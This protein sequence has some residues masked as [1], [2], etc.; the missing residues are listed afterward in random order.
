MVMESDCLS[1][2]CGFNSR[3]GGL[4]T[5]FAERDIMNTTFVLWMIAAN[6][7]GWALG[8]TLLANDMMPEI[9]INKVDWAK[10]AARPL[11]TNTGDSWTNQ[12]NEKLNKI[13]MVRIYDN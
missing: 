7:A 2:C 3:L 10:R 1:E 6:Q 4:L 13:A 9:P 11:S 12:T 5:V 8:Y